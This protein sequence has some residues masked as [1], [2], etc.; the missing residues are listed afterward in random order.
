MIRST[1]VPIGCSDVQMSNLL[2]AVKRSDLNHFDPTMK[3]RKKPNCLFWEESK[4]KTK[5][6][7]SFRSNSRFSSAMTDVEITREAAPFPGMRSSLFYSVL[8]VFNKKSN[9]RLKKK[10]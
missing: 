8:I 7:N 9:G 3:R 10:G 6:K 5:N 4:T 2:L 1:D